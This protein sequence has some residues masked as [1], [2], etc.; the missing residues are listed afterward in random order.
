MSEYKYEFRIR[1][2]PN[3]MGGDLYIPEVLVTKINKEKRGWFY[4]LI[5]LLIVPCWH[6][7]LKEGWDGPRQFGDLTNA[8]PRYC[9]YEGAAL[10]AIKQFKDRGYRN[11]GKRQ[12]IINA[13]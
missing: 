10:W 12:T 1:I 7:V 3:A 8:G 11:P 2:R 13:D 5:S 9:G 4:S 6:E